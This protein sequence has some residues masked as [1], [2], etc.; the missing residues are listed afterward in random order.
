MPFSPTTAFTSSSLIRSG[1][2]SP[3]ILT[4]QPWKPHDYQKHAVRFLLERGAAGLLLDPGLGKTSIVLA[5]HLVLRREGM[6]ERTL[7]I[8]PLRACY[9]VWPAEARKWSDFAGIRTAILHGPKKDEA[10]ASGADVLVVNPEGLEW[11]VGKMGWSW[12]MEVDRKGNPRRR[13]RHARADATIAADHFQMLVVDESTQFKHGTTMRFKLLRSIL[14]GFRRRVI[15]TG[16]PAPNGLVDLWGQ[17]FVLDGGRA[18]GRYISHYRNRWFYITGYGGNEWMI[19]DEAAER[20]IQEAIR[21]LCLRMEATDYLKLPPISYHDVPVVLPPKAREVYARV[22]VEMITQLRTGAVLAQNAGVA[23]TKCRQ[24]AN[25]GVY[26]TD[27]RA[28]DVHAAK[29]D[30]VAEL[31]A[32][33]AGQPALVAYD[34]DHDLKRLQR[35]F[36]QAPR[37][38]GGVSP[39][40]VTETCAAWN[41]GRVP[42]LLVQP[43]SAGRSLNLQG[44]GRAVIWHSLTWNLE[45]YEQLIRRIWRQGQTGRVFV[46]HLIARDTIDEVMMSVVRGKA[47]TQGAFLQA[48]KDRY[49]I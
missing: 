41:A 38:G 30:A 13:L 39:K 28:E 12:S 7:V 3:S 27:G 42:V 5:G 1:R 10:L 22:E 49:G 44:A 40:A 43:Q 31:V 36:P 4:S 19:R 29:T 17:M 32:E 18:L 15:L 21:P 47:K 37:I 11:L 9:E 25:G 20:E 16:T 45:L 26:L 14:N 34:T 46:Y 2:P 24:V 6:V 23:S 35:A 48:M 8:A 33:L